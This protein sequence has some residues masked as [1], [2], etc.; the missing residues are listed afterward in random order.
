MRFF[1]RQHAV[2]AIAGIIVSIAVVATSSDAQ[3]G[4]D[5]GSV[6]AAGSGSVWIVQGG[7]LIHCSHGTYS[8]DCHSQP[9]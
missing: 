6:I 1:T 7:D 9:L 2:G 8:D 3:P 5:G 4:H